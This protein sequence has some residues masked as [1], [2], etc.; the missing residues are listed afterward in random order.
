[1]LVQKYVAFNR[2]I[3]EKA[4][5]L[6]YQTLPPF[7]WADESA[8]NARERMQLD[9]SRGQSDS[10]SHGF[11]IWTDQCYYLRRNCC[12]IQYCLHNID[13]GLDKDYSVA[14]LLYCC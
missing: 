2:Q 3:T 10:S 5:T 12:R 8:E 14:N 7:S 11:D 13:C 6:T 9:A 1:M 4:R